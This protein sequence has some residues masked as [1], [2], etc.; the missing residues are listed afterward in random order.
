MTAL[1][2]I[3]L[4]LSGVDPVPDGGTTTDPVTATETTDDP[5]TEEGAEGVR[6]SPI[7]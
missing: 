3:F 2:L 4:F 7:G 1:I 5:T 6:K